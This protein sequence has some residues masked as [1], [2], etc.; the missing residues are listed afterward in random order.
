[1][2]L[3]EALT[4]DAPDDYGAPRHRACF[5]TRALFIS[6]FL[7]DID[8]RE[9]GADQAADRGVRGVLLQV[10]D[11]AEE[12]FP[13]RG[14]TIFESVSA[15]SAHETLKASEL[16]DRYLDRL[17]ER[18]AD[19]ARWRRDRLAIPPA[20]TRP[21]ARSRRCFGSMARWT[22]P[23]TPGSGAAGAAMMLGPWGSPRPGCCWRWRRCR[24]CG[25]AARGAAR[26]DPAA[27]SRGRA[28]AG[29]DRRRP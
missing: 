7:G 18:K 22:A 4:R 13:Y 28:A 19:L 25:S 16:R 20:I 2:R 23:L 26:A 8:P 21:T 10:L 17:A 29:A 5:R 27:L 1:M 14:R 15:R 24:C 12:A 9:G 11:P 6:D 3:A